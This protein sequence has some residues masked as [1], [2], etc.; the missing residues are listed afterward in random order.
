[1]FRQDVSARHLVMSRIVDGHF[2]RGLG[3]NVSQHKWHFNCIKL[4]MLDMTKAAHSRPG[5][6]C[7]AAFCV[8]N[9]ESIDFKAV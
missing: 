8:F 6:A 5:F 9:V 4:S 1:M 3:L 2:G 7:L